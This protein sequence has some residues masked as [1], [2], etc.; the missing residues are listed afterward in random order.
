MKYRTAFPI[1]WGEGW[2]FVALYIQLNEGE[3]ENNLTIYPML[4]IGEKA[5][6]YI[7]NLDSVR[8][9]GYNNG[10][11]IG[12][13]DGN[14]KGYENGYEDGYGAGVEDSVFFGVSVTAA[15]Q[16]LDG[17]YENCLLYTSDAADE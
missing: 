4:N 3:R 16:K 5:Y 1:T 12:R 10:Y 9:D 15:L 13:Q 7:P 17:S 14:E 8:Q 2:I 6:P 11:E